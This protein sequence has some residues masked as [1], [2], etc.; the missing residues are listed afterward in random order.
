[1]EKA[2]ENTNKYNEIEEAISELIL[3]EEK[4][5]VK[6][7]AAWNGRAHI[8]KNNSKAGSAG[9]TT[10]TVHAGSPPPPPPPPGNG[11]NRVIP[12]PP[13]PPSP[14]PPPPLSKIRANQGSPKQPP[15]PPPPPPLMPKASHG[16]PKPPRPPQKQESKGVPLPPPPPP[17]PTHL[18]PTIKK[19]NL[20]QNAQNVNETSSS[21]GE[22][23]ESKNTN[24]EEN[25]DDRNVDKKEILSRKL[26]KRRYFIQ[27]DEDE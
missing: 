18:S 25:V 6:Q 14:P 24:I 20:Y 23:S 26:E 27:S 9:M 2:I 8:R 3:E 12:K 4:E 16:I 5:F 19:P 15:S 1:M 7:L 13:Q 21:K 17:P 11:S 10:K 22:V